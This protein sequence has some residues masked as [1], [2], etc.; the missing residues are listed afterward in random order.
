MRH[1]SCN[2]GRLVALECDNCGALIVPSPNITLSGWRKCGMMDGGTRFEWDYC[3]RCDE[4]YDDFING[5]SCDRCDGTGEVPTMDYESYFGAQLKPCPK[6]HGT[7]DG[8]GHGP[9][10]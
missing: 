5:R 9:L 10:S 6:C 3:D 8:L 2:G 7:L 1:Y 4:D